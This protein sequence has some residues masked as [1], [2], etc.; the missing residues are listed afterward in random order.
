MEPVAAA[1]LLQ[2]VAPAWALNGAKE[3]ADRGESHSSSLGSDTSNTFAQKGFS[4]YD[5]GKLEEDFRKGE[6]KRVKEMAD[7]PGHVSAQMDFKQ[8]LN[9]F[10]LSFKN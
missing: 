1:Y 9:S 10:D 8:A 2:A 4:L 6:V 5:T 7:C 3:G